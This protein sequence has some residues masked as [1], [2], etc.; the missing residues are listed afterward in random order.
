[1][2]PNADL[3]NKVNT[4]HHPKKKSALWYAFYGKCSKIFNTFLFLFLNKMLVIRAGLQK[5]L[6]RIAARED[7]NQTASSEAV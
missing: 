3:K 5:L 1:M 7:P 2:M 4:M 6:V